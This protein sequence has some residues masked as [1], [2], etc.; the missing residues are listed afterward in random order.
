MSLSRK[1]MSL[2][3]GALFV[4]AGFGLAPVRADFE[5]LFTQGHADI[6][7]HY[8]GGTELE[9]GYELGSNA[10]INGVPV[11]ATTEVG[12]D[13]LTAVIPNASFSRFDG[14]VAGLP[15]V[16]GSNTFWYVSQPN[17]GAVAAPWIGIGAEEISTGIFVGETIGMSLKSVVS[18]PQD[19][20]FIIYRTRIG[21]FDVFIDTQNLGAT[22]SLSVP[23]ASHRHFYFG[24]SQPGTYLL[25]FEAVGNLIGGGQAT[26]SAV[27]AF[28]VVPEPSA[29]MSMS[30][31][32]V[33]I[34]FARRYRRRHA[35]STGS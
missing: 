16:F 28:N 5:N 31:A 34:G 1:L 18:A 15:G 13:Y 20:E 32:L 19:G 23:V 21:G 9:L 4:H 35:E 10:V 24:F 29:W 8:E 33:S 3:V 30:I 7:V 25:E 27:Y 22:N 2:A 26:G 14:G 11:G 17:P 12:A 6:A